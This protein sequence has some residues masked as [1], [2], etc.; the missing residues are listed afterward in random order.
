MVPNSIQKYIVK[1]LVNQASFSELDEL[2]LWVKDP[3]NK[4]EFI[5]YIKI[6]FAIDYHLKKFDPNKT[7]NKISRLI[8][9]E[10]S[11]VRRVKIQKY[12]KYA[13][14]LVITLFATVYFFKDQL[15]HAQLGNDIV[16]E[17]INSNDIFPGS[18]KATL[19]LEDGSEITLK[20][21]NNY[22]TPHSNSDGEEIV[23]H[24][25]YNNEK[26][27]EKNYHYLSIPRA[28]KFQITLSDGTEVW[29]NSESKLKYPVTFNDGK[30]RVVELIY[31]EAYFEVSPSSLHKGAKFKVLHKSQEVDVLGT[32]FNIKAYKDE[33]SI[34]TTLVE[35]KV[36]INIENRKQKLAPHQQLRFDLNTKNSIVKEVNVFDEVSWKDGVFSFEGKTL[37]E[38]MKILSRWYDIN[39]TF[40]DKTIENEEFTGVLRKNK[41]LEDLLSNIKNSRAINDY[42]IK[43]DL[44][45][46]K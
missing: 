33:T 5:H 23:Y 7:K 34:Y 17:E 24:A 40:K 21:G 28:G 20:K 31:G 36:E 13:A 41:T 29:L 8:L 37:K 2:E 10:E 22:K 11:A 35:G 3:I 30:P 38:V 27:K 45:I 1:Y 25:K 6:N 46:L 12:Y 32:A 4:K 19:T 18:D 14:I 9:E 43:G 26:P 42:E 15:F 44:V 39:I 16:L